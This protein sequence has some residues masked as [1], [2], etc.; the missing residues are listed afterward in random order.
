MYSHAAFIG[1]GSNLGDR[2]GNIARAVDKMRLLA[3]TRVEDQSSDYLTAAVGPGDQM[4][5][6]NSVVKITTDLSPRELLAALKAIEKAM[7]RE[8]TYRWGPRIID[9]DIL[10][11]DSDVV[12][13]ADLKIPHLEMHKREFVLEPLSEIAPEVVHPVLKKTARQMLQELRGESA[14]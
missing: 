12:D 5:Y 8:E 10:L 1:L 7:G 14:G 4:P 6:V 13:E 3:A 11:Y 9:L 2:Y